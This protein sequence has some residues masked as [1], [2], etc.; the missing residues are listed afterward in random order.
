MEWK[1]EKGDIIF[2]DYVELGELSHVKIFKIHEHL[3]TDYLH[4]QWDHYYIVKKPNGI[5]QSIEKG[6]AERCYAKVA[7]RE[8][9]DFFITLESQ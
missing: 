3:T 5:A 8:F 9:F 4:N 6:K 2:L 7:S 1:F